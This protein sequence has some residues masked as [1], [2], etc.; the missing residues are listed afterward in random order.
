MDRADDGTDLLPVLDDGAG[1][2]PQFDD[3]AGPVPPYDGGFEGGAGTPPPGGGRSRRMTAAGLAALVLVSGGIGA[4]A[5]AALRDNSS[6]PGP[7]VVAPQS[8][9]GG[10]LQPATPP[11]TSASA[12]SVAAKVIPAVVDI[13]T[14][15][16]QGGAAAGTGM[17]LSA[18]GE[19]LTN[20]HVIDDASDIRVQVSGTGPS[21]SAHVVGYDVTDDVALVQVDGAPPLPTVTTGNSS[22]L[23]VGDP[24]IAIGNAL[25][26]GG[27][28]AVTQGEVTGLNESLTAGDAVGPPNSL[29]GMVSIDAPLQEGDSGGPLV[30]TNGAVVGMDTA[31]AG[32]ARRA[33]SSVGFAIPIDRAL[34]V[35]A[36]IRAG[37]GSNTVHVGQRALLGVVVQDTGSSAGGG[38]GSGGPGSGSPGSG[39]PGAPVSSVQPN[40][41]AAAV[42]IGS[43]DVI[44]D[45]GGTTISQA[46]DLTAALGRY[47]PGDRVSVSWI[48]T[49]G[50]HHTATAQLV[51]GAPV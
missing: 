23:N 5:A 50:R 24:V 10:G 16:S 42:G 28:P 11:T 14:H 43:G 4:G 36:E 34:S 9:T 2:A 32:G 22:A 27:T 30:D 47:H 40:G 39:G 45:L 8:P 29:T 15:L 13:N 38:S 3:G 26:R 44:T 49:S 7:F 31:A 6:A 37:R 41:P 51:A 35:I 17:V 12:A 19:I 46:S 20:N 48:D 1:P 33:P 21:Y 25:G 18:S